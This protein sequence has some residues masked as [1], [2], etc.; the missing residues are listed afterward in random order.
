MTL[1]RRVIVFDNE[2]VI[3]SSVD[4]WREF[5]GRWG[6]VVMRLAHTRPCGLYMRDP[7]EILGENSRIWCVQAKRDKE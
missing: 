4:Q 1:R 2:S 6:G 5:E 7:A 3:D